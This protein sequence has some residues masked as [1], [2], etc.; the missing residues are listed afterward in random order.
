M[1]VKTVKEMSIV[2]FKTI[3]MSVDDGVAT[4]TLNRPDRLNAWTYQMGDELQ[5]ALN[6][7]NAAD[8]V[9][10][11]VVTGAGRGFCAGA[12]GLGRR[13]A[14]AANEPRAEL[15]PLSH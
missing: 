4:I 12:D 7:G 9:G 14:T 11:F 10:A 5:V 3:E 1:L 15:L 2:S 13:P 6:E 8:D